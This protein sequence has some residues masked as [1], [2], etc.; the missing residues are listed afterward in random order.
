MSESEIK[1]KY[2]FSLKARVHEAGFKTNTE[3]SKEVGV[4]LAI[5]SRVINGWTLPSPTTARKMAAALNM[6]PREFARLF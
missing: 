5:V 3:F 4:D 2:R 6:T 1:P